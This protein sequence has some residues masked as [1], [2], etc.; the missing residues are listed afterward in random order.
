MGD[1]RYNVLVALSA[2]IA[3]PQEEEFLRENIRR[4]EVSYGTVFA[5]DLVRALSMQDVVR[6][7]SMQD[8]NSAG[9]IAVALCP[10][11]EFSFGPFGKETRVEWSYGEA[12]G[13]TEMPL[14][15]PAQALVVAAI[16]AWDAFEHMMVGPRL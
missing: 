4:V 10:D 16:R 5:A 6:A 7:L 3:T 1:T 14:G 8:V 9:R 12:S 13:S 15:T 11:T 2:R